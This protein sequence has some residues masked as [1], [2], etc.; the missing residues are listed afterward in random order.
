MKSRDE[1]YLEMIKDMAK[2]VIKKISG[3]TIF[4]IP[5]DESDIDMMVLAAY[6]LGKHNE[7][8]FNQSVRLT[9]EE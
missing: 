1:Y 2:S 6:E 8:L 7:S 9:Q 4:G 3:S 5:V